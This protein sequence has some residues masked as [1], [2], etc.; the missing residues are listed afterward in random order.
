MKFQAAQHAASRRQIQTY[1][2]GGL[3][4]LEYWHRPVRPICNDLTR[5]PNSYIPQT[6]LNTMPVIEFGL[7]GVGPLTTSQ[8]QPHPRRRPAQ[9]MAFRHVG[10]RRAALDA[11]RS[12]SRWSFES[13]GIL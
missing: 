13:I 10:T 3:T 1:I 12:G 6:P 2:S 9:S 8:T 7:M 4:R 11:R 5:Y